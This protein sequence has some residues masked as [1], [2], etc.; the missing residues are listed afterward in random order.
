M[1]YIYFNGLIVQTKD[2]DFSFIQKPY[3]TP[4]Q[5]SQ[6]LSNTWG[7]K[8]NPLVN[9]I[10]RRKHIR[11]FFENCSQRSRLLLLF[12][13][14]LPYLSQYLSSSWHKQIEPRASCNGERK[15]TILAVPPTDNILVFIKLVTRM[16][17]ILST[18]HYG[19]KSVH[20]FFLF[21]LDFPRPIENPVQK[22][23]NRWRNFAYLRDRA[24]KAIICEITRTDT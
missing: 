1:L 17:R 8:L 20:S 15:H 2:L 5:F 23:G 24:Q 18:R 6:Y 16:D 21:R 3:E 14:H 13:F 10:A 9:H 12:T 19:K 7:N 4:F 11:V 22:G